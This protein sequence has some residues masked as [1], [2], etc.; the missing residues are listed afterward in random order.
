MKNKLLYRSLFLSIIAATCSTADAVTIDPANPNL[1]YSGRWDFSTPS[2][3]KVFWQGSTLLARFDGTRISVDFK[4]GNGTEFFRAIVD[5]VA[6]DTVI[7]TGRQRRTIVLAENLSPGEHTV[8]LMKE[9]FYT[10]G[11]TTIYGVDIDGTLLAPPAKPNFRIEFFGDSNMDGTS[12][13]S[14]KDSGESGSYYAY[15]AMV[16][17]MLGAEMNLQAVGGA[18]LDNGGDGERQMWRD[19]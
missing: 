8:A 15:P 18:T 1:Q 10:S 6:S 2:Q 17:R 13:Y 11:G 7:Q 9:T 4:G 14:E 19:V 5:G 12:N 3:P 16:S